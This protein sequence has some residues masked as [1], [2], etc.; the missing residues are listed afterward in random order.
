MCVTAIKLKLWCPCGCWDCVAV[1][2]FLQLGVFGTGVSPS[3]QGMHKARQLGAFSGFGS[4]HTP[5]LT[6]SI[7]TWVYGN[8]SP[9][10]LEGTRFRL[11]ISVVMHTYNNHSV[12][13]VVNA[14]KESPTPAFLFFGEGAHGLVL[15]PPLRLLCNPHSQLQLI[16]YISPNNK[17]VQSINKCSINN[18]FSLIG[19]LIILLSPFLFVVNCTVYINM[20]IKLIMRRRRMKKTSRQFIGCSSRH[21]SPRWSLRVSLPSPF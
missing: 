2:I 18:L 6:A 14:I 20:M 13:V 5:C 8:T 3:L 11:H 7:L 21:S 4:Q 10:Y 17:H 9:K 16:R 1:V 19:C 12:N 15:T